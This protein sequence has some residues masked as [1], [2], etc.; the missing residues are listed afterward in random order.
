MFFFSVNDQ[1]FQAGIFGASFEWL[2]TSSVNCEHFG[3]TLCSISIGISRTLLLLVRQ[4][5]SKVECARAYIQVFRPYSFPSSWSWL[6]GAT[7][8]RAL[9]LRMWVLR[10]SQKIENR[11]RAVQANFGKTTWCNSVLSRQYLTEDKMR[12]GTCW[13]LSSSLSKQD[14]IILSLARPW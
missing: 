12:F 4:V 10:N 13:V 3:S 14:C 2:Q 5:L 1:K 8:C 6:K 11:R 7:S 9:I